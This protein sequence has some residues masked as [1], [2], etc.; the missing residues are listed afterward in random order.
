MRC[1]ALTSIAR[2]G[3]EARRG[4]DT[5]YNEGDE[6]QK[7]GLQEGH[8]RVSGR[9]CLESRYFLECLHYTDERVQVEGDRRADLENPPPRTSKIKLI[10]SQHGETENYKGDD[11]D[12]VRRQQL[13]EWESNC[14][15]VTIK[16]AN[17]GPFHS[18]AD[19]IISIEKAAVASVT[20]V[21]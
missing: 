4:P 12:N 19:R 3:A 13:Y 20:S 1:V 15:V 11:S 9:Q 10:P 14:A 6:Q 16:C 18:C 2:K 5:D 21:T 8:F 7:L 17:V